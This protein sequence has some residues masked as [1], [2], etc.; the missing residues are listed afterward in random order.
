ML[1]SLKMTEVA[2][3]APGETTTAEET[4]L[5]AAD[6]EVTEA[7][8]IQ[9][10]GE[11]AVSEATEAVRQTDHA[12]VKVFLQIVQTVLIVQDEKVD[13]LNVLQDV[14][15]TDRNFRKARRSRRD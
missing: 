4:D 8:E 12:E 10:L 6:S 3:T 9:L 15:K 5:A 1:K 13:F 2:E 7:T 11:K 14:L